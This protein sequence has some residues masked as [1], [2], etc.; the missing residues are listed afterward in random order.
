MRS[1]H[2]LTTS[3]AY[4]VT[5]FG[6]ATII[7]YWLVFFIF[8]SSQFTGCSM[9]FGGSLLHG[10]RFTDAPQAHHAFPSVSHGGS[11]IGVRRR[12]DEDE[13]CSSKEFVPPE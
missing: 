10:N 12:E 3:I 9:F 5:L 1:M 2:S 7:I 4:H 8:H 11:C 6:S 13:D